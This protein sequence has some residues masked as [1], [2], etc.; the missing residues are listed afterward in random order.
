MAAR[1]PTS[2][3]RSSAAQ[4]WRPGCLLPAV[5]L[6]LTVVAFLPIL[7][8]GFANLDDPRTIIENAAVQAGLTWD[9]VVW[10]F[11]GPR[12]ANWI[13]LTWLSLAL[14]V[15]VFG[16]GPFG[17]HATALLIHS[18]AVL[19]AFAALHALTGDRGRSLLVAALFAV[20]PLQVESVAWATERSN[21]LAGFFWFA[22]I[23]LYVRYARRP[24]AGRYLAV[25]AGF[26]LGLMSKPVVVTLPCVLLLLDF[27]PLGRLGRHDGGATAPSWS[28][29]G[30]LTLEKTPLL[31]LSAAT[32]AVTLAAQ[33]LAR[34]IPSLEHYPLGARLANAVV[35]YASYL[36][37][38]FWPTDLSFYYPPA[39]I[40]IHPARI[41]AALAVLLA[42]TAL[43]WLLRRNSPALLPGWLWYLGVLAPMAGVI[44]TGSQSRADRFAYLSLVGVWIAL[45]WTIPSPR[46]RRVVAAIAAAAVGAC[47]LAT[48]HQAR[49]WRTPS[50][51]AEHVLARDP[52]NPMARLDLAG[53]RARE[54]NYDA[55]ID[56]LLPAVRELPAAGLLRATLASVLEA[57]GDL[58]AALHHVRLAAS[59]PAP[60]QDEYRRRAGE[61]TALVRDMERRVQEARAALLGRPEDIGAQIMLGAATL[62]LGR[63][64]EAAVELNAAVTLAPDRADVSFFLEQ[65]RSRR[66]HPGEER[67]RAADLAAGRYPGPLEPPAAP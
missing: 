14:D 33:S 10:A 62:R 52:G 50:S 53:A 12:H 54:R 31:A 59:T 60:G 38:A 39:G 47:A 26:T 64:A 16:V 1:T 58:E 45:A 23:W 32:A 44:Q 8:N 56:A 46:S 55:A 66:P 42:G 7:G 28:R 43:A 65:A 49:L 67:L 2:A 25:V 41:I 20:H 19:F 4:F 34:A 5:L 51:L 6:L 9:T 17:H 57:R 22:T 40:G 13:P 63:Y 18:A 3:G 48:F 37:M 11:S 36:A 27:W 21:L 30:R 29:V 35:G 15:E 24:G 61:L